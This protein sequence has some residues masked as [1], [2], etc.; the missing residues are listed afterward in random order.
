MTPTAGL[1]IDQQLRPFAYEA[2]HH[3]RCIVRAMLRH[4][5]LHHCFGVLGRSMTLGQAHAQ[6][7]LMHGQ[8]RRCVDLPTGL[9]LPV[10]GTHAQMVVAP[11]RLRM[12]SAGRTAR[13]GFTFGRLVGG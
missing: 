12:K 11:A 5:G 10:P 13:A 9:P 1:G 4:Q 7:G 6:P 2:L 3:G 8:T